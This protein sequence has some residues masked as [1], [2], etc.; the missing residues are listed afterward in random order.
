MVVT[1][2]NEV[3]LLVEEGLRSWTFPNSGLPTGFDLMA[4]AIQQGR[5]HGIPDYNTL[6]KAFGL[7]AFR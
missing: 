6:R 3:D 4:Q 7:T 2:A 5:D 1:R